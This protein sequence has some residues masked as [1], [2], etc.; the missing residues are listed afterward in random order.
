MSAPSD[1][2]RAAL[3]ESGFYER[4]DVV[5]LFWHLA[6]FVLRRAD[7][8]TAGDEA[9][10]TRLDGYADAIVERVDQLA[11]AAAARLRRVAHAQ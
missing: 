1:D 5:A 10:A 2:D 11:T 6:D 4:K 8:E 7:A 3:L 9:R